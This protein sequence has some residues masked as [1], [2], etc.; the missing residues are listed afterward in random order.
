LHQTTKAAATL[1]L[2]TQHRQQHHH[3]FSYFVQ[4]W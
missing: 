3:Q 2:K 1:T 4:D